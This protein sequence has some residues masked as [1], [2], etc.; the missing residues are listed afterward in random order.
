MKH[1]NVLGSNM[2]TFKYMNTHYRRTR[3]PS[4]LSLS[5]CA[6]NRQVTWNT[7]RALYLLDCLLRPRFAC[8]SCLFATAANGCLIRLPSRCFLLPLSLET[9]LF[10]QSNPLILF[11][12]HERSGS[13]HFLSLSVSIYLCLY[14]H[15]F[16][17]H[18]R[19]GYR[20][21][22]CWGTGCSREFSD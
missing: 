11:L 8:G 7:I 2:L 9:I 18:R 4:L 20:N 6:S 10:F 13:F 1:R 16:E 21:V 12:L 22:A 15:I 19:S 3:L 14:F 17:D 5:Y